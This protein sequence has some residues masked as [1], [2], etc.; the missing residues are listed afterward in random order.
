MARIQQITEKGIENAKRSVQITRKTLEDGSV[1]PNYEKAVAELAELKKHFDAKNAVIALAAKK[2][3]RR[4]SYAGKCVT[5]GIDVKEGCGF[6]RKNDFGKW[7]TLSF[8]AVQEL[9]GFAFEG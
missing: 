2:G 5:A 1:N 4:N 9:V 3:L 8:A 7:E 6:I